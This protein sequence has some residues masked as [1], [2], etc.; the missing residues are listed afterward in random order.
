MKHGNGG[1]VVGV[2]QYRVVGF[3]KVAFLNEHRAARFIE[4][5]QRKFRLFLTP[6]K[7]FVFA[8]SNFF[9]IIYTVREKEP[10]IIKR[11]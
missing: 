6:L 5:G 10:L 7:D 4:H 9:D 2:G 3:R 8:K 1:S 11:P